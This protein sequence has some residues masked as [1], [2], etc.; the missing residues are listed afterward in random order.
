MNVGLDMD[1]TITASPKF[2]ALLCRAVKAGRGKVYVVTSRTDSP[3]A[4]RDTLAELDRYG[5]EFDELCMLPAFEEAG[6]RC[7][8]GSLDWY[9]KYLWQ[10]ADFAL[11]KKISVFFDDDEKVVRLFA[12]FAP[13]VQ[14]FQPRSERK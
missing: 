3:E 10:K 4:R 2:F 1:G 7:P 8:H 5:I 11:Q 12:E 6:K 9:Q 13:A 14:V